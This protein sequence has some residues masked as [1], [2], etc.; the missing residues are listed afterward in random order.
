MKTRNLSRKN[1]SSRSLRVSSLLGLIMGVFMLMTLAAPSAHAAVLTY[2]NFNDPP[3]DFTSDAGQPSTISVVENPPV[4]GG[5]VITSLTYTNPNQTTHNSGCVP[6]GCNEYTLPPSDTTADDAAG[7]YGAIDI[8]GNTTGGGSICF[9]FSFSTTGT[10]GT[11][12]SFDLASVG[13]GGQFSTLTLFYTTSSNSTPTQFAQ[14]T[15]LNQMTSQNADPAYTTHSFPLGPGADNQSSVTIEFC[16]SGST[17]SDTRNHAFVDNIQVT[18][19]PEPGTVI[20]GLFGALGLGW[21]KGRS[22]L[23]SFRLRRT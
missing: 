22:L 12:V 23:R 3:N 9:Q 11:T 5:Q 13:N 8:G 14:I 2:F 20:G 17:N 4:A 10:T 16:F 15:G 18:G 21:S 7:L 1:I 6:P 19:V